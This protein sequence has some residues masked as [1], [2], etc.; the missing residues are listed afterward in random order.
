M[1]ERGGA[2]RAILFGTGAEQHAITCLVS[3]FDEIERGGADRTFLFEIGAEQHIGSLFSDSRGSTPSFQG[4]SFFNLEGI[5]SF[6]SIFDIFGRIPRLDAI[7][8]ISLTFSIFWRK[9]DK[10]AKSHH[11]KVR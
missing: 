4:T 6:A 5:F 9:K 7:V 1:P 8:Q 3:L 11:R 10:G 2:G